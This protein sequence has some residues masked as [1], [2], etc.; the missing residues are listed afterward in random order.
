[1]DLPVERISHEDVRV[2]IVVSRI[3]A[4][5]AGR[6]SRPLRRRQVRCDLLHASRKRVSETRLDLLAVR[7]R[8]SSGEE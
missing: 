2:T 4:K 3:Q 6:S 8:V 5:L 1:M 7:R